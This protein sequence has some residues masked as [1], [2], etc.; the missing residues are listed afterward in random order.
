MVK[1]STCGKGI[2]T[3]TAIQLTLGKPPL[4]FCDETCLSQSIQIK[5]LTRR[6]L[7]GVVLNKTFGEFLAIVSG[8]GGIAFTLQGTAH[9]ALALDTIS[10]I[11]AITAFIIG[12]EHLRSL[13]EHDLLKKAVL[14]IGIGVLLSITLLVWYFGFSLNLL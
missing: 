12:I 5:T 2:N 13:R 1:C 7:A 14:F 6:T 10:A 8:L 11:T 3:K 9:R 4:F